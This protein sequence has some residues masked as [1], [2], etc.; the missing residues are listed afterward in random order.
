MSETKTGWCDECDG[1]QTFVQE[2]GVFACSMCLKPMKPQV[3]DSV[4]DGAKAEEAEVLVNDLDHIC[5]Y[6]KGPWTNDDLQNLA[7]GMQASSDAAKEDGLELNFFAI[8]KSAAERARTIGALVVPFRDRHGRII[9]GRALKLDTNP[10][11]P[12]SMTK[13][14]R[15]ILP[16][17]R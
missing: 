10:G 12:K 9:P 14:K 11:A 17:E 16:G 8:R 15:I 3:A 2:N 1:E 5:I 7:A 4:P 6:L 13:E